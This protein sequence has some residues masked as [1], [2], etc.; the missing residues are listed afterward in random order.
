MEKG[1]INIYIIIICIINLVQAV[2]TPVIKDEAYYW[3]FAENLDWGFFDHPPLVALLIKLGSSILP[4]AIG[5]RLMTIILLG[6]TIKIMWSMIPKENRSFHQSAMLFALLIFANPIF[7]IY[8]FIT[9]PDVPLLC[10]SAFYLWAL[11]KLLKKDSWGNALW[12]G[13]AAALLIY[14]KY[15]G[16]FVIFLSILLNIRLIKRGS[17]YLAG[18]LAFILITPHLVWQYQH[19]FITFDYHLFQSNDNGFRLEYILKYLYS[20][21]GILNPGFFILLTILLW[22]HS[23]FRQNHPL[24]VRMYI[25][26]LVF[27]LIY[28]SRTNCEA[29][30]V[31]FAAIPMTLLLFNAARIYPGIAKTIK[32]ISIVSIFL[33][34]VARIALTLDLPLKSEFHTQK[35][36]YYEAIEEIAQGRK[37]VFMSS[38]Q[39]A[40]KYAYYTK[41]PSFSDHHYRGRRSQFDLL[42]AERN[43]KDEEVVYIGHLPNPSL[44]SL[45]TS[46]DEKI[47]YSIIDHFPIFNNIKASVE[48]KRGAL[49]QRK[50]NM[51]IHFTNPYTYP[52]VFNNEHYPYDLGLCFINDSERFLYPLTM[53]QKIEELSPEETTI[54]PVQWNI[55]DLPSGEYE[56]QITMK[57]GFFYPKVLSKKYRVQIE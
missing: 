20:T 55:D 29:H 45:V 13:I 51:D 50:G 57:A 27:F 36:D 46:S 34:V 6:F 43:F 14:S 41:N 54:I 15:H 56:L 47:F 5:V 2:F 7:N 19:D 52:I 39:N 30:W 11:D 38:Y 48:L 18:L 25:G 21:L 28:T 16:V 42:E 32:I 53:A 24:Y 37:V 10:A 35:A 4:G 31:A 1:N 33:L 49:I 17:T 22:K 23:A 44:D 8:G 9:T 12:L 3:V 40:A 26:F